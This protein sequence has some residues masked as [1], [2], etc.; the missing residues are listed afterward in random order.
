MV[1]WHAPSRC[2][3]CCMGQCRMLAKCTVRRLHCWHKLCDAVS[4]ALRLWFL[5]RMHIQ[6]CL[7]IHAKPLLQL[8][9]RLSSG[10]QRIAT[11]R[12]CSVGTVFSMLL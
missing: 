8:I 12:H 4:R 1:G 3:A 11:T 9:L 6:Q 5:A 7:V 10:Q 2:T